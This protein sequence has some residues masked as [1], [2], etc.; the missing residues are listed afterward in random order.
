MRRIAL[1]LISV[2]ISFFLISGYVIGGVVDH[3]NPHTKNSHPIIMQDQNVTTPQPVN[4]YLNGGDGGELRPVVPVGNSSTEVPCQG[5][6]TGRL[7]GT[8]IGIWT[9]PEIRAPISVEAKISAVIWAKS[10][11]GANDVYFRIIIRANGQDTGTWIE[12]N[13]QTLSNTPVK[14]S[15]EDSGGGQLQLGQG[16]T[17]GVDIVYFAA[18]RYFFGPSPDSAMIV[19]GCQYNTHIT[20]TTNSLSL[21]IQTPSVSEQATT[22][23]ALVVDAFGSTRYDSILRIDGIVDAQTITGPTLSPSTNGTTITWIWDHNTDGAKS[24]EYTITVTL[25][26]SDLNK[27]TNSGTFNLQFPE[28]KEDPG[29]VGSLLDLMFPIIVVIIAVI[30]A[31]VAVKIVLNRRDMEDLESAD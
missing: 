11:M 26:Y 5:S 1:A 27:F 22:I 20:I 10:A 15:G 3:N 13:T 24:G 17:I 25:A 7:F 19:G 31:I 12:T 9:T 30:I 28:T 16:D 29:I 4:L 23:S 8:P 14:F 2:F 18:P 21:G 6:N